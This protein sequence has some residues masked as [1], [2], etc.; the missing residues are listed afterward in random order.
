[1][2]LSIATWRVKLENKSN[3]ISPTQP[4][5]KLEYIQKTLW[6]TKLYGLI[7]LILELICFLALSYVSMHFRHPYFMDAHIPKFLDAI[8]SFFSGIAV[9]PL[10]L[11]IALGAYAPL[12]VF[13]SISIATLYCLFTSIY[14][15]KTWIK[16]KLPNQNYRPAILSI[17]FNSLAFLP[18]LAIAIILILSLLNII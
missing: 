9:F 3:P 14:Q 13:I 17:T 6:M 12:I 7:L 2:N 5:T 8:L 15:F 4:P 10:L 16:L 1:M 11:I 18:I